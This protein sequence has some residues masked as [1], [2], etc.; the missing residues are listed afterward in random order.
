MRHEAFDIFVIGAGSGGV[1]AA[2]TAAQLGAKVAIAECSDL[3][4]TCVNL[5]CVPKK[6][7]VYASHYAEDFHQASGYGWQQAHAPQFDWPTLRDNKNTEITRLNGVYERLLKDAKVTLMQGQAHLSGVHEV[8]CNGQR[9]RAEKILIATGGWPSLPEIPG[10][11]H[12]ITSNEAFH[13]QRFPERAVVVGGGYIAVEFAGIFNGLGAEVD[14]LYRGDQILRTFDE[15]VQDFV[16]EEITKKGVRI[17]LN[18]EVDRIDAQER[19]AQEEAGSAL[20]VALKN[21]DQLMADTVLYATG[22][23]PRTK[24]LGLEAAGVEISP[25]GAVLVN[26]QYQTSA[27]SIYAIGDVIGKVRL[28]PVAI[29]EAMV[30]AKNMVF[31]EAGT[32]D[33]ENIP[34]A[35]FC[36]PNIGTVGLTEQQARAKYQ[37]VAVYHSYFKAMKHSLS[38]ADERVMMKLITDKGSD[39]VVGVHMVGADAGE[40]IQGMGVALKAGATKAEF[41]ATI[42]IHPTTAEEFVTM[43]EA[44]S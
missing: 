11:E 33:Y 26:A 30:V 6:L 20:S 9:Y 32:L 34:T 4:G 7:F 13:L 14:L 22:R 39:L 18:T 35:V 42:G 40:I 29:A 31:D 38:G 15:S 12:A 25:S 10:I 24:G 1:R 21:G 43:R 36:Q 3:G 5:G 37:D 19:G 27:P 28:T 8:S 23:S 16:A 2:R 41:D 44:A 17:H